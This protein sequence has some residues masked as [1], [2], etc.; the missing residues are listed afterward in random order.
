MSCRRQLLAAGLVLAGSLVLGDHAA[1]AAEPT[2][3]LVQINQQALF[4]TQ[5]NA[6][7]EKKAAELGAK[8]VI[9]NANN[10][11]AAQNNAIETYIAQKVDGLVVVAIDVDE[12][13]ALRH[14]RG[15]GRDSVDAAPR[16]VA[17]DVDAVREAGS[18]AL[19]ISFDSDWR[20]ATSH[21]RVITRHLERARVPVSFRE[22]RS[23]WGH[24]SFLMEIE[25]YHATVRSFL[26]F[27]AT[28]DATAA[29][30]DREER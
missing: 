11:P 26:S 29:A 4:F 17:H 9:F 12:A 3:A 13:V 20:F 21:S 28:T 25:D 23:P 5:M 18:R 15:G 27:D 1:R 16:G 14:L 2:I 19:V 6:G 30:R 24:D 22:I 7:A 10:D 8:L